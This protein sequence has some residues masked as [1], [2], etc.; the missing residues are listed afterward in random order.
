M[1]ARRWWPRG[2]SAFRAAI[3]ISGHRFLA[4]PPCHARSWQPDRVIRTGRKS[5]WIAAR[6]VFSSGWTS[7]AR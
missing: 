3:A 7:A 1:R 6:W 4:T 5:Q 2:E